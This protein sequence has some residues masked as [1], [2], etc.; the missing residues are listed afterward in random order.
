MSKLGGLLLDFDRR[1]GILW[2]DY[3]SPS[4]F[5]RF[6][7]RNARVADDYIGRAFRSQLLANGPRESRS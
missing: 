6:N 1:W 5:H 2:R 7:A 3:I 4:V